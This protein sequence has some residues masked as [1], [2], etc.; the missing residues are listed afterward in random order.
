MSLPGGGPVRGVVDAAYLDARVVIEAD[1]RTYHSR[2]RDMRRD[3]E[4]DAQVV[5][6]VSARRWVPLRRG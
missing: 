1:G 4:R 2:L 3:R 5:Q 6:A